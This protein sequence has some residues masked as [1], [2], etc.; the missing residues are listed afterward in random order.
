MR[1]VL[2]GDLLD[3]IDFD[4]PTPEAADADRPPALALK[5]HWGTGFSFATPT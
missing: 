5:L 3:G 1:F 4:L 2:A